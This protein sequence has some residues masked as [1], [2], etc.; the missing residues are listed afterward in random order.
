MQMAFFLL[1]LL[2][3]WVLGFLLVKPFLVQRKGYILFAIGAGYVLGWFIATLLL[4]VYDYCERLFNIY[5]IVI[6]E[7]LFV[8]PLLFLKAKKNGINEALVEKRISRLVYFLSGAIIT[9]LIYRWSL[10]A[11]DL[12]SKPVFPWDG[13]YSWSSKAK[14]FYFAKEIIP[15][16]PIHFGFWGFDTPNVALVGAYHHPYFVSLVQSY[17]AL[18]WGAWDDNIINIPWLGCSLA[19]ALSVFGGMRYLGGGFLLST[20]ACYATIS[21]PILDAHVSLGSYADLWV[22]L[23]LFIV[24]YLL[25]V[26]L[27][28]EE[29]LLLILFMMFVVVTYMTKN[30]SLPFLIVLILTFVCK[31]FGVF[32][33]VFL[34]MLCTMA[35]IFIDFGWLEYGV[36]NIRDLVYDLFQKE[37]LVYNPVMRGVWQEWLLADNFHYTF[38]ASLGSLL[39]VLICKKN[40]Y[41]SGYTLL[42]FNGISLF[43]LMLWI[44]F[45][46]EILPEKHFLTVFGRVSLYW[47]PIFALIPFC[48]YSLVNDEREIEYVG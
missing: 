1:A 19:M 20:T 41:F 36:S 37:I 28:Y 46:T 4:R 30:T 22:S 48:A 27:V 18:A 23:V 26:L 8:L 31:F 40:Q 9:L 42:I 15:L 10:T 6:I 11:I 29:W 14:V 43:F 44:A 34:L 33:G 25:V 21:L 38:I 16:Y 5:E 24:V 17:V 13:W 39:I 35:M 45:F 7:C 12:L 2:I 32:F 3:P 47:L